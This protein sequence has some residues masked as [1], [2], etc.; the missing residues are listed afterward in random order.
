MR[1][2]SVTEFQDLASKRDSLRAD[3]EEFL[4]EWPI[5]LL[6][7]ATIPAFEI[8]AA[9]PGWAQPRF[10]VDGMDQERYEIVAACWAV[11][12][13]GFPSVVIPVAR[14]RDGLPIGVQI[15]GRPNRDFEV[16]AVALV[17]EALIGE[18]LE[19]RVPGA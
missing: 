15:V 18:G 8:D 7:V 6:P 11:S 19:V 12:L 4:D 10:E 3:A 1:H 9:D 2:T 5:W 13:Y 14:S 16:L 17:L